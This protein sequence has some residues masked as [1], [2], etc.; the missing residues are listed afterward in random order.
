MVVSDGWTVK[1]AS[2]DL[3]AK[4]NRRQSLVIARSGGQAR[5]QLG[6]NLNRRLMSFV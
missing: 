2:R 5:R 3:D 1:W 4:N 6:Q